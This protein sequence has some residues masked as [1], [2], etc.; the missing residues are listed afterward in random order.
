MRH[1]ELSAKP[2]RL[3]RLFGGTGAQPMVYGGGA[4]LHLRQRLSGQDEQRGTVPPA[5]Q[6]NPQPPRRIAC[7]EARIRV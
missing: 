6:G 4:Q 3:R 2:P 7:K 1:I 5:G